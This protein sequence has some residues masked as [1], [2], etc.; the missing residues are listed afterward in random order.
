M[1]NDKNIDNQNISTGNKEAIFLK[2]GNRIKELRNSCGKTQNDLAETINT[3]QDAISKIE[4]GKMS[5]SLE[6]LILIA[7]YFNVSCDYLIYGLDTNNILSTLEQYISLENKTILLDDQS[8]SYP[9]LVIKKALFCYLIKTSHIKFN[10]LMPNEIKTQ[11]ENYEKNTFYKN[12]HNKEFSYVV[13]I[14]EEFIFPDERKKEW[15]QTDLLRN[16]DVYFRKEAT[17]YAN[18]K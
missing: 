3:T 18:N 16:I 15:S 10:T 13:P 4:R 6:N 2:I 1:I 5:I 9:Q 17:L 14:P 12:E 11:W 8:F 7:N